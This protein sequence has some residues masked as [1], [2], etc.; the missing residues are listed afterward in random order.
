MKIPTKL[1]FCLPKR[2]FWE[3][4]ELSTI[5]RPFQNILFGPCLV[6]TWKDWG[7]LP[8]FGFTLPVEGSLPVILSSLEKSSE[9]VLDWSNLF[10]PGAQ[11]RLEA[12]R[13]QKNALI[14]IE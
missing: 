3:Y 11:S 5:F 2:K 12:I 7:R 8:E 1:V 9:L 10:P 6:F 14:E 13:T 4:F